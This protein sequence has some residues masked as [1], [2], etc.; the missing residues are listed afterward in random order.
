MSI[1][2]T[3]IDG[4]D[5]SA[6]EFVL[7]LL[8][9][10]ERQA[11]ESRIRRDVAFAD[12]VAQWEARFA[13]W[14]QAVVPVEA[15][16]DLW[17]RIRSTLWSHELPQRTPVPPTHPSRWQSLPL[18]RGLAIGGIAATAISLLVLTFA[19]RPPQISPPPQVVVTPPQSTAAPMAVILREDDGSVAYTATLDANGTLVVTPVKA[20][21][22]PRAP[23][24]WLIPP[25]DKPHSLG[26]LHRDRAMAVH[27][28]AALR[29]VA[30][31][32]LFAVSLEPSGSGPHEAPTGPVIAK[33]AV[34]KL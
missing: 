11:A 10:D 15:P 25:G 3:D 31:G 29:S 17:Q 23:E 20:K 18:W 16:S 34:I 8:A 4:E 27:V 9:P 2:R 6:A 5:L 32:S 19:L 14:L 12:E 28:P 24:L 21:P 22:D 7:G 1:D 30:S 13:P 26:M 33:G